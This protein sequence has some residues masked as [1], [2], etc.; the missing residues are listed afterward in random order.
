[1][2]SLI[3]KIGLQSFIAHIGVGVAQVLGIDLFKHF[4]KE[5]LLDRRLR[6]E[7]EANSVAVK[8]YRIGDVS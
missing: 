5:L 4:G 6:D 7:V 8:A 3:R 2:G 1:M